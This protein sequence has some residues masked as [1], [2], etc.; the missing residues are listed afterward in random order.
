MR[1]NTL[2]SGILVNVGGGR[3]SFRPLPRLAQISPGF[4]IA[5]AEVDGDG[6]PDLYMVQNFFAPQFETGRMDGGLSILMLG[7][8]DATFEPVWPDKSGLI[9]PGDAKGL[10]VTDINRDGWPDFVVGINDGKLM[11]FTNSGLSQNRIVKV[12]LKGKRGNP[13][14]VGAR[15]RLFRDDGKSQTTEIYAGG[16]YLSQSSNN[17]IFGLGESGKVKKIEVV[18]PDGSHTR[19]T[20]NLDGRAIKLTQ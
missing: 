7:R 15:V 16:G 20:K 9:V 3:F 2:E 1:Q 13:T 6:N 11:A 14:A 19:Y 18:W 8:G 5:F 17:L 12:R 10:S 4:G